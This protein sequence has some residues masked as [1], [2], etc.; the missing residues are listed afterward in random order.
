MAGL[1]RAEGLAR[2]YHA[3][4]VD[5]AGAPYIEHPR[6]VAERVR[7]MYPP[8]AVVA[9][10]HDIVEDTP[11][12]LRG[13]REV[14]FTDEVVYAVEALTRREGERSEDY[15]KR[16]RVN[17]LARMVKLADIADNTDPRRLSFLGPH[18]VTRLIKKYAKALDA[19]DVPEGEG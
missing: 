16:V 10:L 4:Q 6:R 12:T 14:G 1:E 3:G 5:K 19:L 13:L 2:M 18:E 17:P 9:W 8:A 15:Y 7:G 11:V